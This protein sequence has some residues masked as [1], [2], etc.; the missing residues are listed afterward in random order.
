MTKLEAM[1]WLPIKNVRHD[2]GTDLFVQVTDEQRNIG[3]LMLAAQVKS[4]SSYFGEPATDE[5]GGDGWIY[6]ESDQDH[7]EL[8]LNHSIPHVIVLYDEDE[9]AAY[10]E[11]ISST[12]VET[13]GKGWKIHVSANQLLDQASFGPLTRI[14]ASGR[15]DVEFEVSIWVTAK[16]ALAPNLL[17]RH[18]MV[19]PRLV[20]PHRNAGFNITLSAEQAVALVVTGRLRDLAQF[21]KDTRG[22]TPR[23]D[24]PPSRPRTP[25]S[26]CPSVGGHLTRDKADRAG[27]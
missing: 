12:T 17:W 9:D 23:P 18:G 6:R 14:A 13:T 11:Q 7:L 26:H 2:F 27:M 20:A 5:A 1:G 15:G 24:S 3:G 25:I 19:A 16:P 22:S 4:G 21:I 8:W 10:W